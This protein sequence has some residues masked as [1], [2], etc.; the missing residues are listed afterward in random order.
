MTIRPV[1][2]VPARLAGV[3]P[4]APVTSPPLKVI[5]PVLELKLV[6]AAELLTLI[7]PLLMEMP[8]PAEKAPRALA[9]VKY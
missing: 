9:I 7:T 8:L 1:N 3:Y 5:A 2:E 6:T 4:R